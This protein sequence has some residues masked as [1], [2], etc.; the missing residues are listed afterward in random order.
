M[1]NFYI[2]PLI[3]AWFWISFFQSLSG[4]T[5]KDFLNQK[6][7][8]TNI[9]EALKAPD[10]V[11]RLNLTEKQ[12]EFIPDSMWD[13]FQNL[14]YLSLKNDHLREI[15]EGIGYLKNLKVLD[16]SGNDF[17]VLPNSF[18]NL[19]NLN[20]IYLNDEKNMNVEASIDVI[21]DLPNLRILHLENDNLKKI[22]TSLL[23]LQNLEALYINNN[24]FKKVPLEL[25]EL[26]NLKFVDI[27]DNKFKLNLNG[28]DN[29][30]FGYK[31]RF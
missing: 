1:T 8:F 27:H 25:G 16:L 24:K 21:K 3:I 14:E 28:I 11:Y 7:E 15:P 13:K 17:K 10:K 9:E 30:S 2:R 23:R 26:K 22:P 19:Y 6:E 5:S 20:E 12:V 31:M 4:Q 18:S 29:Q